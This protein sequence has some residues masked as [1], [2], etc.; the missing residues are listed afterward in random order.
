M[1]SENYSQHKTALGSAQ[2]AKDPTLT[3]GELAVLARS[4]EVK[5]RAAVAERVQTPLTALLRLA[6]DESPSVRAGVARNP[7]ADMPLAVREALAAD[8]SPEVLF[9]LLRCPSLPDS[10]LAKLAKSR[11]NDVSAAAKALM[12]SRR[13]SGSLGPAGTQV[14]LASS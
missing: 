4:E 11:N 10:V 3:D 12:K 14:G 2:R 13:S 8:R 1:F 7:R 9:G 5:V 6:D